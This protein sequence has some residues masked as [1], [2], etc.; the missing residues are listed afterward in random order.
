V[1]FSI[2]VGRGLFEG[3]PARVFPAMNGSRGSKGDE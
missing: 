1:S 3:S 2:D